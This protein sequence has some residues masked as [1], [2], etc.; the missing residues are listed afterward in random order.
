MDTKSSNGSRGPRGP[1]SADIPH[2]MS[3]DETY[4]REIYE[5]GDKLGEGSFGV[6]C[7]VEHKETGKRYACKTINK[8]KVSDQSDT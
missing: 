1:A 3:A 7:V 8:E 6:V 2:V 5:F 4:V